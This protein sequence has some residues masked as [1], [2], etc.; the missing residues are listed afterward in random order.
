[1]GDCG[2]SDCYQLDQLLRERFYG[3]LVLRILIRNLRK[4]ESGVGH[5]VPAIRE[6]LCAHSVGSNTPTVALG[7]PTFR[8]RQP[9][10]MGDEPVQRWPHTTANRYVSPNQRSGVARYGRGASSVGVGAEHWRAAAHWL[11]SKPDRIP[12]DVYSFVAR[13]TGHARN[14]STA[15]LISAKPGIPRS[16]RYRPMNR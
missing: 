15:R 10:R 13:R 8:R 2:L 5:N 6:C 14:R 11:R 7:T 12:H 3:S 1:M 16:Y 9:A 4:L